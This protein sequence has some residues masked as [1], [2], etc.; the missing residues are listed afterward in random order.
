MIWVS[1]RRQRTETLIAA[2][3]LALLAVLLVPTGL[4]MAHAYD[5]DGLAACLSPSTSDACD[6]AISSFTSRFGSISDFIAWFT[7]VPGLI[8]VLLA[9]PFVLEFE[10]GTHRLA[11]TQSVTRKRWIATKLGLAVGAAVL[12]ALAF[13]LLVT[14]WRTPLVHLQ[15]RMEQSVYDSEGIVVFG[16]TLFALGLATAIGVLWRR[17]VPAVVVG[18]AGYFAA[19]LFV[20][21]WLRERRA[22]ESFLGAPGNRDVALPRCGRAAARLRRRVDVPARLTCSVRS[23]SYGPVIDWR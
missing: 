17:G 2:A 18:F 11:W 12:A 8:G 14:W 21:T 15:G 13:T 4:E 22:R 9:A 10:H 1:W 19:R 23:G 3:V 20:D 6:Q 5:R 16:Y 7:L